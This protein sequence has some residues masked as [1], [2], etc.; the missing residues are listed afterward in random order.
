[1]TKEQQ[2]N[3]NR[4]KPKKPSTFGKVKKAIKPKRKAKDDELPYLD[5]LHEDEQMNSYDCIVCNCPVQEWHHIKKH[6]YDKKNHELLIPLCF[7]HHHGND[8][9]PHGRSKLWRSTYSMEFQTKIAKEIHSE[10]LESIL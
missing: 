8:I 10:Y 6:S 1:M 4:I 7:D 5:W 9:S 3:A 2:L